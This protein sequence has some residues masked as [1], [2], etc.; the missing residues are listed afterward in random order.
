MRGIVVIVAY[1]FS[2]GLMFSISSMRISVSY[3]NAPSKVLNFF[4]QLLFCSRSK[5]FFYVLVRCC[6]CDVLV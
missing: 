2:N 4:V 3:C 5:R 1:F 6:S